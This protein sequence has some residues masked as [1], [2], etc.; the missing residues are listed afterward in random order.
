M[1]SSTSILDKYPDYE[2]TIGIEVHVQLMTESK[3]FCASPNHVPKDP[4]SHICNICAGYPGVLPVLNKKVVEYAILTGLATNSSIEKHSAF[5]RKHYFY[6]DLPKNYQI[7]QNDE[8]ICLHGYVPIRLEDGSIKNI[9]LRR[10]H[11]EED[12]GKNIHSELSN[13]SFVDLNRAGTPLLEVVTEPD[14]AN[15]YE[16]KAYLKA[17]R[18]ICRHLLIKPAAKPCHFNLHIAKKIISQPM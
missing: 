5:D 3:I 7:T 12:A 17:L 14:I 15:A 8:P 10:I 1:S 16:A 2:A 6:P 11:I 18:L 13:E 4:N 9:R